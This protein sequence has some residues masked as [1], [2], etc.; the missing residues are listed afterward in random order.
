VGAA[1]VAARAAGT[2]SRALRRGGGTALPGLVADRVAPDLLAYLAAQVPLGSVVVTGTN[3]KTTTSHMLAGILAQAGM[4][5][6][7]NA[8]GSNLARGVATTLAGRAGWTGR[9]ATTPST[10]GLFETDEAAFAR[11]VPSLRPR[12]VVVTNLF[13]DQLDRYGEVDS[14][15]SIWQRALAGFEGDRSPAGATTAGPLLVLNADDPSIAS[16]GAPMRAPQ[17]AVAAPD[18]TH[19]RGTRP[20]DA[21][22]AVYYGVDDARCG[23]PAPEHAADAKTCPYCGAP[24]EYALSFYGHLGHYTCL[25][26]HARPQPSVSAHEVAPLGLAGTDVTIRTERGDLSLRL[27]LP[28]LYNVYNALAAAA[29]AVSLGVPL[30]A[31]KAGLQSVEAAFGRFE[32]VEVEGRTVILVLAKNP[33]GM[34][35]A[36]RTLF[37]DGVPKRLLMALNDLDADGRDVSW[38]WDAEFERARGQA[39]SFVVAGRRAHD[40]MLRL[41]YA[42]ALA[43]M[44]AVLESDL[45]RA[46]DAA[47]AS[48]GKG[49]TLYA[50]LTYTAMLEL[51]RLLAQ[52]GYLRDYWKP[53]ERDP[54]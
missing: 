4:Q 3:G 29:A 5:P 37:R 20:K 41:K 50:V 27:P 17:Q 39:L 38:I 23:Q 7:R 46:L 47:L 21:A 54:A 8:S 53:A 40:L 16:L 10:V 43:G 28:G 14:V 9:L 32:R 45:A 19:A 36:L 13:R 44:P 49:E 34:N 12:I 51:R 24:L 11:V 25:N 31:V 26:G 35:E 30:A 6:L 22:R 15:R 1:V 33:V 42:D 2:V 18:G 52:R 48:T